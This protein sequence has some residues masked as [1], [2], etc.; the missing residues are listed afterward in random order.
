MAAKELNLTEK[1]RTRL[2]QINEELTRFYSSDTVKGNINGLPNPC[3]EFTK[4]DITDP[5][6]KSVSNYNALVL[7]STDIDKKTVFVACIEINNITRSEKATTCHINSWTVKFSDGKKK[8]QLLR[9]F[10]YFLFTE[11]EVTWTDKPTSK[12]TVFSSQPVNP[13][14]IY[15]MYS[16]FPE[17][18]IGRRAE[19]RRWDL[20][21]TEEVIKKL[22][23]D[24]KKELKKTDANK[25]AI[26]EKIAE[27]EKAHIE[28]SRFLVAVNIINRLKKQAE[29]TIT[30]PRKDILK[31]A[32]Q[33]LLSDDDLKLKRYLNIWQKMFRDMWSDMDAAGGDIGKLKEQLKRLGWNPIKRDGNKQNLNTLLQR[34]FSYTQILQGI[35]INVS[36]SPKN[37]AQCNKILQSIFEPEYKASTL[38]RKPTNEYVK[39]VDLGEMCKLEQQMILLRF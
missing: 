22:K 39:V 24:L 16:L 4:A 21:Q 36:I 11:I 29:S 3:L 18:T 14:S 23:N 17:H 20:R 27:L 30:A 6:W 32:S 1:G 33:G 31:F 25:D 10:F 35:C 9:I 26:Q 13:I 38:Y 34:I 15:L 28:Y 7:S 8:N 37:T 2:K 19:R 12:L 5:Q